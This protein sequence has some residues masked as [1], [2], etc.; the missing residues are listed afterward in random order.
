MTQSEKAKKGRGHKKQNKSDDDESYDPNEFQ[1]ENLHQQPRQQVNNEYFDPSSPQLHIS[2]SGE[3]R[4]PI[5]NQSI[6]L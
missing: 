5:Y 6:A 2:R 4:M 1:T 3:D